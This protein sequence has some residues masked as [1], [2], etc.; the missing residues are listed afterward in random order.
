MRVW[1]NKPDKYQRAAD[2]EN[3]VCE[4]GT[5]GIEAETDRS[6]QR[7]DGGPDVVTEK[8]WQC[9][10]EPDETAAV[11]TSGGRNVLEH[12]DGGARALN[13][14]R[15][16]K[17]C[18]QAEDWHVCHLLDGVRKH[19]AGCQRFHDG[20]HDLDP[21]KE[22]T[23]AKDRG[24]DVLDLFFFAKE[25]EQKTDDDD[26]IDV[27]AELECNQLRGHR[28]PDVC[29]KND[30]NGLWQRHQPSAD[31]A[32]GHNG[33]CRAGLQHSRDQ[34]AREHPEHRIFREHAED[35]AHAFAG[36][37]LQAVAHEIHPIKEDREPSEQPKN[38]L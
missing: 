28:R 6:D 35:R 11:R 9:A 25:I 34:R 23:K 30:R 12:S 16:A 4:R 26:E 36:D 31:E 18:E 27:I 8:H 20:A 2:V 19:W 22:Q 38:N 10:G 7:S 21:V 37:F 13:E 3:T 29:T 33:R 14:Q 1:H 17:P 24:T 5:L 32:D 15:H